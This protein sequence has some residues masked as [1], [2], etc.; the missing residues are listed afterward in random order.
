M[1]ALDGKVVRAGTNEV[2]RWGHKAQDKISAYLEA[3]EAGYISCPVCGGK[4]WSIGTSEGKYGEYAR[5]GDTFFSV[6]SRGYVYAKSGTDKGDA[7]KQAL[8][9]MLSYMIRLRGGQA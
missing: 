7:L 8:E 1:I 5:F 4:Y 2:Y 6:N 9:G 3:N